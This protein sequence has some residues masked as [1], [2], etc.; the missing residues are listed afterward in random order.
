MNKDIYDDP[1]LD[2][3]YE[4]YSESSKID[5]MAYVRK[6]L[7]HKRFIFVVTFVFA[8][9]GCGYAL[10]HKHIWKVVVTL[11]PEV[12]SSIRTSS[13]LKSITSLL[14]VGNASLANSTDALNITLS[15]E[16]CAST[17]FLIQ[18]FDVEINPEISQKEIDKGAKPG[19]MSVYT[20]FTGKYKPEK[21]K[22][23]F[24]LWMEHLFKKEETKKEETSDTV[25]ISNLTKEQ[26]GVIKSLRGSIKVDV[27]NKSGVTSISVTTTDPMVS[28]QLADTVSRYLQDYI[29]EYRTKKAMQDYQYYQRMSDEAK[30]KMIQA[31]TAYAHSIDYD[32]SV[33]L[34]SV[35]S[36][37][38][39]LQQEA[40]LAQQMY[41]QMKIQEDAYKAKV[42]ELRPV[43]AIIQ[44][45]QKP[46]YPADSRKKVVFAFMFIG[47]ILASAWK[48]VL[49]DAI[50]S[51]RERL[52]AED[53][54]EVATAIETVSTSEIEDKETK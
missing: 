43:F 34:Q 44:P 53:E 29:S 47:F 36:E 38:E 13:S 10:M 25:N 7:S 5:W 45:A 19:P 23:G 14:G 35:S 41:A 16:I 8:L 2:E 24:S 17:P 51:F 3:E 54:V 30:E 39:R 9:L 52:K 6:F 21:E 22:S 18:L 48:V 27:D 1:F 40:S 46:Q 12:Q 49:K 11:A 32:R 26:A 15:S 28:T 4:D 50:A 42:Q 31:Q 20:Y 33:I 37:K